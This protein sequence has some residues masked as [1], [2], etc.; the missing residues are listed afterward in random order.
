MN[1]QHP[2]AAIA[3]RVS[4]KTCVDMVARVSKPLKAALRRPTATPTVVRLQSGKKGVLLRAVKKVPIPLPTQRQR[5]P[6]K[7][8]PSWDPHD[9]PSRQD[10]F[11]KQLMLSHKAVQ[12]LHLEWDEAVAALNVAVRAKQRPPAKRPP[13]VR[14]GQLFNFNNN[15]L[16]AVGWLLRGEHADLV[17]APP[18]VTALQRA[19][20]EAIEGVSET[21]QYGC[22]RLPM[23][24]FRTKQQERRWRTRNCGVWV[25]ARGPPR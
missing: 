15:W 5:I 16:S 20:L 23:Q 9:R 13:G 6:L 3:H 10:A 17:G 24:Y 21:R 25:E 18:P 12:D 19:V 7:E 2:E 22:F 14:G 11:Q 1:Q 8:R 4:I